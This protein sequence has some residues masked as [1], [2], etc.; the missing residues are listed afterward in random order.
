VILAVLLDGVAHHLDPSRIHQHARVELVP[1]FQC[2]ALLGGLSNCPKGS[3]VG[4]TALQVMPHIAL[5][6]QLYDGMSGEKFTP[7]GPVHRFGRDRQRAVFAELRRRAVT[8]RIRPGTARAIKT[9]DPV[10][11]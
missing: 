2:P 5:N 3:G 6:H 7:D 4:Q 11:I 9:A 10:E 1:G 8:I